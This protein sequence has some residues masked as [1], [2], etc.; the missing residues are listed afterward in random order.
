LSKNHFSSF[1]LSGS[2]HT[3]RWKVRKIR[4]GR[5]YGCSLSEGSGVLIV[6]VTTPSAL[7]FCFSPVVWTTGS[8]LEVKDVW[9]MTTCT[10]SHIY[11]YS[12]RHQV[13]PSIPSTY[14]AIST[15]LPSSGSLALP[16][17]HHAH[18]LLSEVSGTSLSLHASRRTPT[19]YN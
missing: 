3:Y 17:L 14:C 1:G 8:L 7:G 11:E 4:R 2:S 15:I 9:Y 18:G 6:D 12:T 16:G 13:S 19:S 5:L 10:L